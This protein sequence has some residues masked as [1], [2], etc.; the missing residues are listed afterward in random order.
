MLKRERGARVGLVLVVLALAAAMAVQAQ[1]FD[2]G[3]SRLQVAELRGLWRF[4]TGDNPAWA[5]PEY[6]DSGWPLL[7]SDLPWDVQGYKGYSG[8]AWYRFEVTLPAK[9]GPLDLYMPTLL[10]SY[11]I[12]ANGRLIGQRGGLPPHAWAANSGR[13]LYAIPANAM[14]PGQPLK[15]AIRVWQ[16]PDW[17]MFLGG[18]PQVSGTTA[19]LG[20]AGFLENYRTLVTDGLFRGVSAQGVLL[21]IN[22]L[23]G[24]AGVALYFLGPREREY[25]WFGVSEL[26][27][28]ANIGVGIAEFFLPVGILSSNGWLG[29]LN[30]ISI[31]FLLA[32]LFTLLRQRRGGLYWT[33]MASAL[34]GCVCYLPGLLQWISIAS[35]NLLVGMAWLPFWACVLILLG[36]AARKG[37]P[38]AKL[39]LI[40][41]GLDVVMNY[42]TTALA[43]V[44]LSGGSLHGWV[45][46]LNERL[47]H[48]AMWP[49]PFS[50]QNAADFLMQLSLVGVLILRFARTR[51]DEQRLAAEVESARAV[52]Q[53]LVPE[54]IPSVPGLAIGCVYR[55]A[56][57][58]GGDFF[59]ILP[60]PEGSA[61]VAIGD[62][63]GK[64][65]AAAMTVSMMVGT[66]RTLAETTLSPAALLAGMNRRMAG[67]SGGGFTTCLIVRVEAEGRCVAANAGHLHPYLGGQELAMENG[68]PLGVAT[69]AA[70]QESGFL[71]EPGMQLTLISDGVVEARSRSGELFGFERTQTLVER[72]AEAI[73]D[74]AQRFGHNDDI[75]VVT[76]RR[77]EVQERAA[78][79]AR[80]PAISPSP[81]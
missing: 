3:Q 65:V 30:G 33:A 79:N 52:Q 78:M 76:L 45:G 54:E 36:L 12:F 18:G 26:A 56:G 50:A 29:V 21:L 34:V 61:L 74:A 8:M 5:R 9:H 41:V 58:V 42:V 63:S 2:L 57:E 73:A 35:W 53:V 28:A 48:L 75:T 11:Q 23:A 15:V 6:D 66:L 38:D 80:E 24:V 43:T 71:L 10:T 59:Q 62:V 22:L 46:A 27:A 4:H 19:L 20:D 39:L 32:F 1:T 47:N 81:A 51:R 31:F 17:A 70:Y 72:P 13:A 49:V 67:R 37:D 44:T 77:T 7:R 68:L 69:D 60:G 55:P 25:L 16:W 64:G 40:P 14:A